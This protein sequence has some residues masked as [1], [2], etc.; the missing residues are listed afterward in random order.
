[1]CVIKMKPTLVI[2]AAA[3]DDAISPIIMCP[4][5]ILA[6]IRTVKVKGRIKILAVS[7]KTNNGTSLLGAPAGAKWA[8][9]SI[10]NL[11]HPEK[12]NN[13]QKTSAKEAE[14]QILLVGP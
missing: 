6:I 4:A 5:L 14:T 8:A 2:E 7:I 13:L 10:G 11:I 9:D 12:I 1:M 3:K